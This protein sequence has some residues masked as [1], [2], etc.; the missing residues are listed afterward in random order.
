VHKKRYNK[1]KIGKN[2][3]ARSE[4]LTFVDSIYSH[5]PHTKRVEISAYYHVVHAV[6]G[7]LALVRYFFIFAFSSIVAQQVTRCS[8]RRGPMSTGVNRT[9][10]VFNIL[11]FIMIHCLTEKFVR[12]PGN[13]LVFCCRADICTY[14][15]AITRFSSIQH[16][17]HL[18]IPAFF[19]N[20]HRIAS[21]SGTG[22]REP[23][24]VPQKRNIGWATGH[25]QNPKPTIQLLS[26]R[27]AGLARGA[28]H[29]DETIYGL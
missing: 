11:Y 17:F 14:R 10:V 3:D 16:Y 26:S 5:L 4:F 22:R 23:T 29:S 13:S 1:W 9:D 20:Q 27:G 7:D 12:S 8:K 18:H 28:R 24:L 15:Q 21:D 19:R 6:A 2:P 25:V